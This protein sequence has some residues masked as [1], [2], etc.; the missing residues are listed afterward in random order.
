MMENAT[1]VTIEELAGLLGMSYRHMNKLI[2][3]DH[4]A[5]VYHAA[6]AWSNRP[7]ALSRRERLDQHMGLT[8]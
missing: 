1:A 2:E 3:N 6:P 7:R 8:L 4:R 5:T